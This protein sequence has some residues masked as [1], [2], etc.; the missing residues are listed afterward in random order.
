M[1]LDC[2]FKTIGTLDLTSIK[3]RL[4]AYSEEEWQKY[5][6]RQNVFHV[7][8]QTQTIGVKFP[9]H[10]ELMYDEELAKT[11]NPLLVDFYEK[12]KKFYGYDELDILAMMFARMQPQAQIPLHQDKGP[13]FSRAHRIHVPIKTQKGVHFFLDGDDLFLEEGV[14]YEINNLL[15]HGVHN[16]TDEPRIHLIIDMVK[17]EDISHSKAA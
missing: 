4:F 6:Y 5:T 2:K 7:H 15:T 1:L 13:R 8:S 17:K 3:E 14:I 9:Q 12:L 10:D 16:D 11:W